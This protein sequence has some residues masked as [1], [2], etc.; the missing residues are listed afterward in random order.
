MNIFTPLSYFV[1]RF[2]NKGRDELKRTPE[3]DLEHTAL[4]GDGKS[5]ERS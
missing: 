5:N 3:A 2:G 4:F 1:G